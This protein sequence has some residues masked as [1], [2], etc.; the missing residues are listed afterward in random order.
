M[1]KKADR[2]ATTE[3]GQQRLNQLDQRIQYM[4][5]LLQEERQQPTPDI[6]SL[7]Q[8]IDSL[9]QQALQLKKKI[10]SLKSRCKQRQH[11]ID[12]WHAWFH[13]IESVEK[14]VE[15]AA[16][17][18]QV[19]WRREEITRQQQRIPALYQQRN[20]AEL[21]L[22]IKQAQYEA[23]QQGADQTPL[24]QDPRLVGLLATRLQVATNLATR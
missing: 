10:N 5:Q 23:I 15:K 12:T 4:R 14:T 18:Q 11:E 1:S 21:E 13:S 24:E 8:T 7:Q 20:E 17:L 3:A 16:L 9:A 2:Q 6:N 22:L 19:A